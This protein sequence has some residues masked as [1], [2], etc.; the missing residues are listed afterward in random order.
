M[1]K[2]IGLKGGENGAFFE[3]LDSQKVD[4]IVRWPSVKD[5]VEVNYPLGGTEAEHDEYMSNK[6]KVTYIGY[7]LTVV[8]NPVSAENV[9]KDM[10]YRASAIGP[11]TVEILLE[12]SHG[13]PREGS[14]RK[15]TG[16]TKHN[17]YVTNTE[18]KQIKQF[19]EQLRDP[20]E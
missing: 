4:N 3:I 12:Q 7:R 1:K 13:G 2:L 17:Y 14:G 11:N 18:D 6:Q 16:R 9:L 8:G 10:D 20:S 5:G 19:I 15:S